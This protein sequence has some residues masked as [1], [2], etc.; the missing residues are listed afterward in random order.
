MLSFFKKKDPSILD[1]SGFG[2][3]I[4]S[5]LIPGIDD[6]ADTVET[7]V[8][9]IRQLQAL[10]YR[11]LITTPHIMSDLYPNTRE[12]ILGG[13]A[14]LQQAIQNAGLDITIDAAAEYY[15]DEHFE[16]IVRDNNMLTLPGN[17]VLV[18]MSFV[19]A[20]PNLYHNIFRLQTKG[21]KPV[22]AHP[23]RYLFLKKDFSQY[24]RLKEYGC[25][26]QLNLLSLT[27]YYGAPVRELALKLLKAK[28]IDFVGTD[29]HHERHIERLQ[30]LLQDKSALRLLADYE[31]ANATLLETPDATNAS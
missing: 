1:F 3:D 12:D 26:F 22:L 5:H 4:H 17:R 2:V 23:E 18:E 30:Q 6:G 15:M 7:S 20:P 9:L 14:I 13:L 8:H 24:Q 29:L 31:F 25:E 10:G 16:A 21:Y 19:T 11:H 27:G 28:L